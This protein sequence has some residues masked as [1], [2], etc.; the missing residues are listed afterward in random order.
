MQWSSS[1]SE[2]QREI[3]VTLFES[4]LSYRAVAGRL[5]VPAE[6]LKQL[7][8]RWRIRG[9]LVLVSK[10]FQSEYPFEVKLEAVQ[11]FLAGE[12]AVDLARE[13]SVSSGG[14]VQ[15]WAAA[16]RRDGEQALRRGRG[17]PPTSG[18][19]PRTVSEVDRLR[20]ENERLLAEVAYLKKLQALRAQE[21][22]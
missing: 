10:P 4:G 11:R 3:A 22:Q 20:R 7:H 8:Q 13:F 1:L 6:R 17:R 18:A 2:E 16:Y 19:S 9:R 15:Q 14:L 5:N 21:R 12:P